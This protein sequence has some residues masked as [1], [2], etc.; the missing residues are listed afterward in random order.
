MKKYSEIGGFAA[1]LLTAVA[2]QAQT[3]IQSI[4][5]RQ[6]A[7]WGGVGVMHPARPHPQASTSTD[8]WPPLSR[9]VNALWPTERWCY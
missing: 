6:Y 1:L 5:S 8:W 2:L 7:Q 4:G 3:D 9:P